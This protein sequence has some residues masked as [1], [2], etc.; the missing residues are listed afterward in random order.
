MNDLPAGWCECKLGD[1]IFL[2]NGFAFSSTS[3]VEPKINSVPVIRISDINGK[4]ASDTKACHVLKDIVVTGFEVV[5]G[6]LLIAMSGA[7]TGKIGAYIGKT[8]AYQNQRV[9]NIK[10]INNECGHSVYRNYL[11]ASLTSDILKAAYG[12]AQPNISGSTIEEISIQLAPL[13]EQKRIAD[14]LDAVLAKVDAC[15]DRL[16]RIPV[17]LKRFRQAVLSAAILGKLSIEWR[18]GRLTEEWSSCTLKDACLSITDGDHQAPPQIETGIPFIT[19]SAINDGKLR[20]EK[21]SRFVPESYFDNLKEDRKPQMGDILFS[22]TGSICI[23][24]FVDVDLPFTFQRHIAILRPNKTKISS[25]YLYLLLGSDSIRE[26]GLKSATG[27]AQ[28]TI[29]LTALRGFSLNLPPIDEQTEIVRR[30]ESLFAYADRLEARYNTA[31]A[32]VKKL[33]P[34]LLAK[35]FRG[36]LVPQDPNDEPASELLARITAATSDKP[37]KKIKNKPS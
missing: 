11:I 18:S 5:K 15:R 36:E 2:K 4:I 14:K 1:Y 17:I 23:P 34:A 13:N 24:A 28:L 16:D 30:V 22:V 20:L 9:G 31:H 32:Q 35:A 6:D 19:I 27:T 29:P 3:Y 33:T 26:Q 10:L 37:H 8:P 21:A 25:G 7:T 12:G